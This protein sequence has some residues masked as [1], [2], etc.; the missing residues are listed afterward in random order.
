MGRGDSHEYLCMQHAPG[1]P[2]RHQGPR[3]AP[4]HLVKVT[5]T[6]S[7]VA[8]GVAAPRASDVVLIAA[9]LIKWKLISRSSAPDR[10]HSANA[11]KRRPR[12]VRKRLM[13][14][15]RM[16]TRARARTRTHDGHAY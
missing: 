4:G 2:P 9:S 8:I 14:C 15:T 12:F 5:F 7:A 10:R 11:L 16:H 3:Y 6:P 1:H 13:A